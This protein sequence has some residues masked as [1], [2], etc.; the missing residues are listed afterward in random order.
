[1]DYQFTDFLVTGGTCVGGICLLVW[2]SWEE[3]AW[4]HVVWLWFYGS[5]SITCSSFNMFPFILKHRTNI[6]TICKCFY[7]SP[8]IEMVNAYYKKQEIVQWTM[9][10]TKPP[11]S[12]DPFLPASF[13][14]NLTLSLRFH[15]VF[16]KISLQKSMS[17]IKNTAL[18]SA[19]CCL[20]KKFKRVCPNF[21]E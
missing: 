10:V 8:F 20:L 1:M 9:A 5:S 13:V 17:N 7:H 18:I 19:T 12:L 16:F 2:E 3:W 15:E 6:C 11:I 21:L 14:L 4:E